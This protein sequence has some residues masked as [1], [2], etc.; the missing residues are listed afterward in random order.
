MRG[1]GA[2]QLDDRLAETCG[3]LL[4]AAVAPKLVLQEGAAAAQVRRRADEDEQ[5]LSLGAARRQ[6]RPSGPVRRTGPTR[7]S[8]SFRGA[9]K[10][11]PAGMD[12]IADA[13]LR[14]PQ[15][16]VAACV[17]EARDFGGY[18]LV[19]RGRVARRIL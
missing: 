1:K 9:F 14:P 7:R 6:V 17:R 4:G 8:S 12:A 13:I 11:L 2:A 15:L 5:A 19:R 10:P 18:R 16:R 3:P